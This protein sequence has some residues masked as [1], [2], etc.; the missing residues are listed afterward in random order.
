MNAVAATLR[1]TLRLRGA[2]LFWLF[3]GFLLMLAVLFLVAGGEAAQ[4]GALLPVLVLAFA[5]WMGW[6]LFLSRL[7]Q[8]QRHAESLQLPGARRDSERAALLL[9]LAGIGLPTLLLVALGAPLGWTLLGQCLAFATVLVYLMV[10][11][12]VGA[13]LL[14][15]LSVLPLLGGKWLRPLLPDHDTL[16]H[17]LWALVALL[18]AVGLPRWRALMRQ[19]GEAGWNAPQVISLAER[20]LSGSRVREDDPSMQWLSR[21][22]DARVGRHAGPGYPHLAAAIVLAGPL[23][24]LGWRNYLRNTGWMLLAIGVL[25][26]FALSGASEGR[27]PQAALVALLAVWSL[28]VPFTLIARLRQLW[29]DEGHGLAEASLLPGLQRGA[30]SWPALAGSVLYT[31]LYRLALP[32]LLVMLL[33]AIK[34]GDARA[35][36]LPAL[37]SVWSI[38][39][40]MSL[41]PL[42][43]RRGMLAGFL[44][45]LGIGVVVVGV[46]V[47][48][49]FAATWGSEVLWRVLL[50]V[51]APVLLLAAAGWRLPRPGCPLVQP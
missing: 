31:T 35:P 43:R 29:Q 49:F 13:F 48:Q 32:V 10:T 47:A 40:C 41:L 44:L 18:V 23:A 27:G 33:I 21:S 6:M 39:L 30:G 36:L 22:G 45:Y 50:P 1:A 9:V 19:S 4:K 3:Y 8:L 37:V 25:G 46:L 24:P 11:P 51:S 42:A 34:A 12:A 15:G 28:L 26:L 38:L 17:A 14:L 5:S 7:W 16:F 20:G 2:L